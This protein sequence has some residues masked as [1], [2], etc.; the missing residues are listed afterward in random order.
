[1]KNNIKNPINIYGDCPECKKSWKGKSILDT[2]LLKK[3]E[4]EP[5]YTSKSDEE[6]EKM[7]EE[8][9]SPPYHFSEVIGIELSWDH[10]KH[11]DGISYY[12]CPHCNST[13][14]RFTGE[15]EKIT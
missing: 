15:K 8:S 1:M 3:E 10:P 5:F 13:F 4:G 6:I 12:K 14:N 9:Y 2:F 11:Y 7:V